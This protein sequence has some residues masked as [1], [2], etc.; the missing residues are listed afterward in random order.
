MEASERPRVRLQVAYLPKAGVRHSR[1][2]HMAGQ[3]GEGCDWHI[4]KIV[5]RVSGTQSGSPGLV[6]DRRMRAPPHLF[7]AFLSELGHHVND[8]RPS[9]LSS[10][11][12]SG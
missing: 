11:P 12:L 6:L 5:P 4:G 7:L 10:G 1:N 9:S 3:R 2:E 8:V